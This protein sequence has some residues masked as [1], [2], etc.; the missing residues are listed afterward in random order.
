MTNEEIIKE[1]AIFMRKIKHCANAI[2]ILNLNDEKEFYHNE[3]KK[4]ILKQ[5]EYLKEILNK[6]IK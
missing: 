4:E 5:E 1:N 3:L 2:K 6:R